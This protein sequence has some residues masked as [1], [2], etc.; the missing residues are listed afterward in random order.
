MLLADRDLIESVEVV[1]GKER[2]ESVVIMIDP[3]HPRS[4]NIVQGDGQHHLLLVV[5]PE[6]NKELMLQNHVQRVLILGLVVV[7]EEEPGQE[8]QQVDRLHRSRVDDNRHQKEIKPE[9]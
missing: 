2:F 3:H 6:P 9:L 1:H 7:Q 8:I 4:I 5:E